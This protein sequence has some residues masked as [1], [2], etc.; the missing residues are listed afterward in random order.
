MLILSRRASETINVG[1][2]I[3]VTVLGIKGRQVRIGID[4]PEEVPVNREE[5][6]LRMQQTKADQRLTADD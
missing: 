1:N 3:K 4:A 2:N 5:I 6:F